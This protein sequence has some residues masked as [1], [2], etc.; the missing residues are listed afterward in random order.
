MA[1]ITNDFDIIYISYDEPR[2]EENWADLV[3][4]FPW[5]KRVHKVK[6]F[7]AA[8]KAAANQSETDR[9]ITVDGDNKLLDTFVNYIFPVEDNHKDCVYSFAAI[10]HIN[11]LVYGNNGVKIWPKHVVLNMNSHETAKEDG[12]FALDFCWDIPYIQKKEISSIGYA[13]GSPYQ[14]F[15]AGFREGVKM[16]L[17][18][19]GWKVKDPANILYTIYKV[20]LKRLMVWCSVGADVENGIW[21][22]YGARLGFMMTNYSDFPITNINNYDWFEDFWKTEVAP[23][24]MGDSQYCT[25][26]KYGWDNNLLLSAIE[27]LGEDIEQNSKILLTTFSARQSAFIK[28]LFVREK[29]E[30]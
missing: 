13:N 15:R 25:F 6:G 16:S 22:M 9:F 30:L 19:T 20:N 28:E 2:C 21:S 18:H 12:S 14:A 10:N 17:D 5:A 8:H 26:T 11:G 29:G 1:S 3:G 27:K 4:K 24:F 7:D 23:K